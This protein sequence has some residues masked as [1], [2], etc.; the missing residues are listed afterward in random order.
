MKEA[1]EIADEI[2]KLVKKSPKREAKLE[3]IKKEIGDTSSK[4]KAF[5]TTRW[6]VRA[7][8]IKSILDNY[9]LLI[10]TF[11]SDVEESN[12]P[13]EM[14]SRIQGIVKIMYKFSSYFNFRLAHFVLRHTDNLATKLQNQN[15]HTS[16]YFCGSVCPK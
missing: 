7:N 11:E 4:I 14:K 12:M 15:H 5:S 9:S 13:I 8:S 1:L 16:R 3:T 2:S 6:T 10:E